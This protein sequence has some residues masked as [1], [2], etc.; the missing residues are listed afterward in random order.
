MLHT[1]I[2]TRLLLYHLT[3]NLDIVC[4]RDVVAPL[5]YKFLCVCIGYSP[6]LFVVLHESSFEVV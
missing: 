5:F 3:Y 4:N 6:L 2:E 1:R